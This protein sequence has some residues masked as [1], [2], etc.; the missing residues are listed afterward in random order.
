M[1][2]MATNAQPD[3]HLP[4]IKKFA[5]DLVLLFALHLA[6]RISSLLRQVLDHPKKVLYDP[7]SEVLFLPQFWLLPIYRELLNTASALARFDGWFGSM[8][9]MNTLYVWFPASWGPSVVEAISKRNQTWLAQNPVHRDPEMFNATEVEMGPAARAMTYKIQKWNVRSERV[10][11]ILVANTRVDWLALDDAEI[12]RNSPILLE[13]ILQDV[14][15]QRASSP[16]QGAQP[17]RV[18]VSLLLPRSGTAEQWRDFLQSRRQFWPTMTTRH[19]SLAP[20]CSATLQRE[21]RQMQSKHLWDTIDIQWPALSKKLYVSKPT[22]LTRTQLWQ[23]LFVTKHR[24]NPYQEREYQGDDKDEVWN[25]WYQAQ[26]YIDAYRVMTH[27]FCINVEVA[28][29][30]FNNDNK[31]AKK[32]ISDAKAVHA[33]RWQTKEGTYRT[34]EQLLPDVC[35]VR[36]VRDVAMA[37]DLV[38]GSHPSNSLG[39]DAT[40]DA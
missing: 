33:R 18:T 21:R 10:H 8:S 37:D 12:S 3:L 32:A 16:W 23:H 19:A 25:R 9:L 13:G 40:M 14:F 7:E 22:G 6:E 24:Q 11:P 17:Q 2:V 34:K 29:G 15:S 20:I 28:I 38:V 5:K 36:D 4:S 35:D 30:G 39:G 1:E 26:N 27:P 31:A